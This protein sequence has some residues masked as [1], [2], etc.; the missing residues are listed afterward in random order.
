MASSEQ[1]KPVLRSYLAATPNFASGKSTPRQF[2]EQS[3]ELLEY[4]EPC[5]GAFVTTNLPAARMAAER[6]TERWRAGKPLSPIDG[7][8]IGI[9]DVIETLDMPTQMGSPLYAGWRSEKDA[10]SVRALRDA[11]AIILGKTVT[12]EFAAFH[13]RGTRNPWNIAHTP[14]GS[15][16]GSAAAVGAGMVSAALGTQVI[17]STIRPASF[18][19][20]VGF[21]PSVNALNREGSHDYQSQ[22][23]TGIIGAALGDVWQVVHE[24]VAGVG[25][26]AGT[27]GLQGPDTL[28][29]AVKPRRLAVLETAGW[30]AASAVAKAQL[31]DCV[32][33]LKSAG[34]E[35]R[36]RQNDDKVAALETEL[37]NAQELSHRCNGWETRW[38]FRTMRERDAGKLSRAILERSQ[39]YE[40]LT[41][42]EHRADLKER[43][44]VRAVHA[45]LAA[46]CDACITL[47]AP[48][49]APEGL[50]STGN[51]EFAVPASL[52]GVPAL[53]L[54]LFEVDGM[55]LGLQVIGYFDRDADAF[56]NAG[57]L[58]SWLAQGR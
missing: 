58:M 30:D 19:G 27:P 23:C 1:T 45:E 4:W 15:S 16:S 40:D 37:V 34:I 42:A 25:G 11:G 32:M 39:K 44:R 13:P 43:A 2:L 3:L 6:S 54:P 35:I 9:K 8:P 29:Q 20:C 10:A 36:T 56:A 41:L 51:P 18:C 24:I 31:S 22:S 55:P 28:P 17:G 26:D 7:M 47:A 53:S 14:G 48:S 21:K 57:W 46:S 33:R 49:A 52:L 38:F 12:T 50:A 5:I